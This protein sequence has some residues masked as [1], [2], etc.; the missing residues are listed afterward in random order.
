MAAQQPPHLTDEDRDRVIAI[1]QQGQ[2][3]P[4]GG[5]T[6]AGHHNGTHPI[7][8]TVG[9]RQVSARKIVAAYSREY[10]TGQ[11][12]WP[13]KP[14]HAEHWGCI[15]H[16]TYDQKLKA[17]RPPP[18]PTYAARYAPEHALA[19][20]T[21]LVLEHRKA[22]HDR[23]GDGPHACYWCTAP[24]RWDAPQG[25]P[26][27]LTVDHLDGNPANNDPANLAPS[28]RPC[29]TQ[30][31]GPAPPTVT[32]PSSTGH[33]NAIHSQSNSPSNAPTGVEPSTSTF[34]RVDRLDRAY[35]TRVGR[36]IQR[37]VRPITGNRRVR[38]TALCLLLALAGY[39][40]ADV[41][42]HLVPTVEYRSGVETPR[43]DR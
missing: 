42:P 5:R 14:L 20:P 35:K 36:V 16:L 24:L 28:C 12:A 33:P 31:R 34:G 19:G 2:P 15:D 41:V 4:C 30:R 43:G 23:I 3:L 9:G 27:E 39:F 10:Y 21:G 26:E 29:N 17:K 8:I 40:H 7:Y 37:D 13:I 25:D 6:W 22:L 11:F 18:A 1:L 32:Q 38:L